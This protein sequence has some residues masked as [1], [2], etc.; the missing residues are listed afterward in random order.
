MDE[1]LEQYRL[2]AVQTLKKNAG[3]ILNTA[4]DVLNV[5]VKAVYVVGS[6]LDRNLFNESSDIDVAVVV[7]GPQIETGLSEEQSHRLQNE[8]LRWPLS[9]IGIVNTLVFVNE[10]ELERGKSLKVAVRK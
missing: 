4:A 3:F 1:E 10:M 2:R 6:V 7:E 8:M 5:P 9:E